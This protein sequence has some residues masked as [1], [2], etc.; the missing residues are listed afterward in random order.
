MNLTVYCGA[1]V[2]NQAAYQ[3]AARA[4]GAWMAKNG[5]GLVYGGGKIGIMGVIAD[6]VLDAGGHVTGIIPT[7]LRTREM[8]HE[9]VT[10]MIETAG[11]AERKAKLL[12]LGDAYIALP[13]GPGTLEEISEAYSAYRLHLHEKPCIVFNVNGCYDSLER[14]FDDM[15]THGFLSPSDRKGIHF[16]S[17]LPEIGAILGVNE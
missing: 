2:G 16:V 11:M 1:N 4:L 7:F 10:E 5:F 6:A 3:D 14:Y 8:A 17:S 13:G 12:A 9:G 15:V